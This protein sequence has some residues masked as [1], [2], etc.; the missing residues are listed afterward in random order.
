M[1]AIGQLVPMLAP[2]SRLKSTYQLEFPEAVIRDVY[3]SADECRLTGKDFAGRYAR[4]GSK[5][6]GGTGWLASFNFRNGLSQTRHSILL[7]VV[8]KMATIL[9]PTAFRHRP[10]AVHPK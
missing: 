10:S 8:D 6:T 4:F 7:V 9:M 5:V 1:T 3:S 2:G